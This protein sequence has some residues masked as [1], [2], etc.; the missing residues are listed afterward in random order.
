ESAG[1]DRDKWVDPGS[2]RGVAIDG[3]RNG[4]NWQSADGSGWGRSVSNRIERGSRGSSG[5][6]IWRHW[7]REHGSL[8]E[9]SQPCRISTSSEWHLWEHWQRESARSR[10]FQLGYGHFQALPPAP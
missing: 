3:H 5:A 7:V 1:V 6:S 4:T 8:R 2:P 10:L 9:L